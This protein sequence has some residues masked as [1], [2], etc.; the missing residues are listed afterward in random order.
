MPGIEERIAVVEAKVDALP[1]IETQLIEIIRFQG[2]IDTKLD[3]MI[4]RIAQGDRETRQI[5]EFLGEKVATNEKQLARADERVNAL[6]DK[7][8]AAGDVLESRLDKIE[9]QQNISKGWKLGFAAVSLIS[10]VSLI[11]T[12][13]LATGH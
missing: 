8:E 1:R 12:I 13:I 7:S 4:E 10:V 11:V 9:A 2:V 3:N 5:V 6:A